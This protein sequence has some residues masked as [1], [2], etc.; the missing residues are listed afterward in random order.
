MNGTRKT[1]HLKSEPELAGYQVRQI[2]NT[3]S[4]HAISVAIR[5][6]L[7]VIIDPIALS[8]EI[9]RLWWRGRFMR[10]APDWAVTPRMQVRIVR[11]LAD[12]LNLPVTA[13][14]HR[15]DP[16]SLPGLLDDLTTIPV[17]TLIWLWQQAP[18]IYLGETTKNSNASKAAG[19]HTMML[20]AYDPVHMAEDQFLTPWGFI[21]PWKDNATSLYW[22]SDADFR[23]AWRFWLPFN[24]PN[25]LV[26]IR[27]TS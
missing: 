4:F 24:G 21:N 19:G 23:K 17:V 13:T 22:I 15:G 25:P 20:A 27:K 10:V 8:D 9:S 6:L 3:C 2:G 11:F 26:M 16:E 14:Y 1:L 7:N 5:L 18:P 12:E